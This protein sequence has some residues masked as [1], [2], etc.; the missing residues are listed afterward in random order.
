[1]MKV[2]KL[3]FWA[4]AGEI[5]YR[6]RNGGVLCTVADTAG[7]QNLLTVGWG[8]IGP[9]YHG[10][11]VFIIAVA[12]PRYSWRFLE[13][14]P[15]FVIAVPDDSLKSE[16]ALCGEKSG[17]DLDK[18]M[19]SGLTPVPSMHVKPP[20][21]VECPINI[22]CRVYTKV[23]P[24]HMLLTPEHRQHPVEQQHTIYFAEV[25]GVMNYK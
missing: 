11:P 17:R 9:N 24:P 18:F 2:K 4:H 25:L 8:Q 3:D 13:E 14:V 1:M 7:K 16:V 20:S 15:E 23:A 12:Q 19:A 6:M 21:L 5:L 22:E 10:N